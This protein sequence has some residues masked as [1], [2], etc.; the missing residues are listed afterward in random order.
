MDNQPVPPHFQSSWARLWPWLFV[1]V[2]LLFVGCVRVRLLDMPLE[3]D[4]GE[5]AYAGQLILQGIP[6]YELAYN[7][8]LP[9]TY[10]AYALGMA[11]FGETPAGIHLTLLVANSL[12][13]IFVFLLGRKLFGATAG[14][15]ACASYGVM[16][17]SPAVLGMAA[18]ANHFVVLFAVPATLLL[19]RAD[20]NRSALALFFS[21]LLYGLA[22]L[23]IQPGICFC[24][25]GC[26]FL[27]WRAVLNRSIF[28]IA[29]VKKGLIFG[30][31]IVLPF[32]LFCLSCAITWHFARFWFWT[33][34]YAHNYA[35]LTPWSEGRE[36]LVWH[37]QQ[38]WNVSLGL[39]LLALA[40]P[41]LA[42]L[43]RAAWPPVL[44]I[45]I[46]W[47]FS[48]LGTAIG[49]YFR[50]HYFILVLPAFAIL[51]GMAVASLQRLLQFSRMKNV[52]STLPLIL[53][54]TIL[55][56]VVF[57]QAQAFFQVP[58]VRLGQGLYPWNPVV[59]SLAAADYIREHSAPDAR[60]AVLGSEPEIYFYAHRHSATGYIYTYALMEPQPAALAM[61][62]EMIQEIET[63]RP[64]YLVYVSHGFSW[65]FQ[66]HS[67]HT[68]LDWF[69]H[70]SGRDYEPVGFVHQNSA[71]EVECFWGDAAKSHRS[72]GEEYIAVF[73]RKPA[74]EITPARAN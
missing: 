15:V 31:G 48:F 65:L 10:Y 43:N 72:S 55:S 58:P 50:A 23:M 39:W 45:G 71:G 21:G 2:V 35:T 42:W 32:V 3:R 56:W 41:P 30:L 1:L 28:S 27:V 51:T 9:G 44:F 13:I 70:Y 38:T 11:V 60:V 73:Q 33:F 67:D 59:E 29:F 34:V 17:V 14:L 22:F 12:T 57:Y 62:H 54:A 5:Y 8:K 49:F 36:K 4:E 63:S 46:F 74:S 47:L 61:Q 20:E 68:I 7:M 40:G 64:E 66:K 19:L 24:L 53:F 16:S 69:K 6:P 37:L 52:L 25:F 18:H 26:F